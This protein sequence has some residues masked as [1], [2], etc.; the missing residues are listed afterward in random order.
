VQVDMINTGP[1]VQSD[2]QLEERLVTVR[3][4]NI[5]CRKGQSVENAFTVHI[6]DDDALDL[7][8]SL[9]FVQRRCTGDHCMI[10]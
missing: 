6:D 7:S 9:C 4:W 2:R 10:N 3:S 8:A 1:S 5:G